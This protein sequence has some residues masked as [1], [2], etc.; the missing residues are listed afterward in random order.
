[1]MIYRPKALKIS[2][3]LYIRLSA[4]FILSPTCLKLRNHKAIAM[5]RGKS[6][7]SG[8]VLDFKESQKGK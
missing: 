5:M 4:R 1:M 3:K 8:Q 6:P 2:Y 7:P